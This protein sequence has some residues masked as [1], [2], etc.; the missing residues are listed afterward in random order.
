LLIYRRIPSHNNLA[1][2]VLAIVAIFLMAFDEVRHTPA[3]SA[4][5]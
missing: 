5:E 1:G 2:M 4:E 3:A